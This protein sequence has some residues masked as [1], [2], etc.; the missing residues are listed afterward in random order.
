M[1]LR[2]WGRA[3]CSVPPVARIYSGVQCRPIQSHFALT[4]ALVHLPHGQ[5]RFFSATSREAPCS[6]TPVK[7]RSWLRVAAELS[8][9]R[10]SSL[11][12]FTS[13][14]GYLMAGVPAS[15]PA[16]AAVTIGT[17]LAAA[18]AGTFNQV[19]ETPLDAKMKRTQSRPL[20][21]GQIT[22]AAAVAF[23]AGLTV[24]SSAILLA[25]TNPLTAA[26]GLGNVALYSLVYT[27]LKT[28]S[29]LSTAIGAV[30]GAVP[31]LMGWAA[32]TG[33]DLSCLLAAEPAV[34][35]LALFW[36][37]FP[38]FYALGW[39]LRRDY[40]R[41][42]YAVVPATDATGSRTAWLA[43]RSAVALSLLPFAAVAA[44][45]ANPMFAVEG[46]ALNAALLAASWRFYAQPSDASARA[47]FR[48]TLWY[49][50]VLLALL[51]FH[52]RHWATQEQD[53]LAATDGEAAVAAAAGGAPPPLAL[54]GQ[55]QAQEE[56]CSVGAGA[57]AGE[58][59]ADRLRVGVATATDSVRHAGRALCVHE[60]VKDGK[61]AHAIV[62]L[63]LPAA[64]SDAGLCPAPGVVSAAREQVRGQCPVIVAGAVGAEVTASSAA[65]SAEAV[66]VKAA[67]SA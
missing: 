10:L 3:G 25:G 65:A 58:R 41:G 51:V 40:I 49:L 22:P 7:R 26:L 63:A 2:V 23:G 66:E 47:V 61:V 24:A 60:T 1:R 35:G 46:V 37:Q 50:P 44:G 43:L 34:L 13:G 27:P 28:R 12:V 33:G 39:T 36:W 19:I 57:A 67:A 42:G 30:V 9:A 21:A 16:F 48:T 15:W 5:A 45:V 53:I 29:E 38:H 54:P 64:V 11:V 59:M 52:S 8:K 31:P 14:A 6:D 18:A 62:E 20:P 17:A 55:G 32:A 56:G 4:T